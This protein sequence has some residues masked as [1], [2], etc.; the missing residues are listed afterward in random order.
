M[1]DTFCRI[2]PKVVKLFAFDHQPIKIYASQF[3]LFQEGMPIVPLYL[4]SLQE[5][6]MSLYQTSERK[7]YS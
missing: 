2:V 7:D 1:H 4:E 3:T 6:D 5:F